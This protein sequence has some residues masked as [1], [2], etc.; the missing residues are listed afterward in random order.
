MAAHVVFATAVVSGILIGVI[1][2]PLPFLSYVLMF[3]MGGYI[4]VRLWYRTSNN[5]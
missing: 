1:Y 5:E 3:L 4:G 2:T